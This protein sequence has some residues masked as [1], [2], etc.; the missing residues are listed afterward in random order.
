MIS[1][2]VVDRFDVTDVDASEQIIGNDTMKFNNAALIG[3]V[4]AF[5]QA[6]VADWLKS[7]P[8]K[9]VSS[10]AS[11]SSDESGY[12]NRFGLCNEF[13]TSTAIGGDASGLI[14]IESQATLSSIKALET[15]MLHRYQ[16][17]KT[18]L[19]DIKQMLGCKC[20]GITMKLDKKK[21]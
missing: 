20:Q 8:D 10:Y 7:K 9:K 21:I 17:L 5:K 6:D 12:S 14:E 2:D 1:N 15:N 13:L 11:I 3:D 18:D 16:E 4:I 19:Q